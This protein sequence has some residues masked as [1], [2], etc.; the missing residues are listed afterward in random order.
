[1]AVEEDP[2]QGNQD[3]VQTRQEGRVG[4][5]RVEEGHG[6]EGIAAEEEEPHDHPLADEPGRKRTPHRQADAGHDERGRD[7]TLREKNEDAGDLDRLLYDDEGHPPE[8]GRHKEQKLRLPSLLSVIRTTH[9]IPPQQNSA[10]VFPGLIS[11]VAFKSNG[12]AGI[13]T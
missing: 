11:P 9:S 8:E 3:D 12:K 13:I 5:R 4:G 7:E 6:L 10:A 1:M 2:Q